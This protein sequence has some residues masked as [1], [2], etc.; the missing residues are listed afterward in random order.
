[1][2]YTFPGD[3]RVEYLSPRRRHAPEGA[4]S[5]EAR[6]DRFLALVRAEVLRARQ[7]FPDPTGAHLALAEEAGEVAKALLDECWS[8]VAGECVQTAGMAVRVA[9][10]GDPLV[11]ILRVRRAAMH[12]TERRWFTTPRGD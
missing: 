3:T 2:A 9:I 12:E 6:L 8:N 11:D 4:D 1:M 10:E 5:Y 7:L